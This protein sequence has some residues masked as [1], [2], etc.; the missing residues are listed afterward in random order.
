MS[1]LGR[2]PHGA[3]LTHLVQAGDD[4]CQIHQ[5]IMRFVHLVENIIPEQANYVP[6]SSLRPSKFVV[7]AIAE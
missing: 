6:V 1:P 2:W 5:G 7:K 4:M 3:A